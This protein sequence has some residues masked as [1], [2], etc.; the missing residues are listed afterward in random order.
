MKVHT[1]NTLMG[2]RNYLNGCSDVSLH[3][4]IPWRYTN[5]CYYY[6]YEKTLTAHKS[7]FKDNV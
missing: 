7:K 6:H 4:W 3:L 2:N 5:A 1:E